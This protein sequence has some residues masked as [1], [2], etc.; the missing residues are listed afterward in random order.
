MARIDN[1]YTNSNKVAP[2]QVIVSFDDG[3][4]V[5]KQFFSYRTLIA[6]IVT[7]RNGSRIF[8]SETY[9]DYSNTTM[10]YLTQ[11]LNI[12]NG[13]KNVREKIKSGE[14]VTVHSERGTERLIVC[15]TAQ[16]NSKVA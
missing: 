5:V 6:E 11:F 8:L 12:A 14:Y 2:N 9:Y 4:S 3:E 10:K 16:N 1:L 7:T 13:I 15:E